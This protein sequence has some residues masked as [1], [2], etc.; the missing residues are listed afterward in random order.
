MPNSDCSECLLLILVVSSSKRFGL[1]VGAR[2]EGRGELPLI[3]LGRLM[4]KVVVAGGIRR[5]AES[6]CRA[7][8]TDPEPY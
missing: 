2:A 8:Q 3:G 7:K 5:T 4:E 6:S 1:N